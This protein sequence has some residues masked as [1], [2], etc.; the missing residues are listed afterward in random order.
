GSCSTCT[1][2]EWTQLVPGIAGLAARYG[3]RGH[4]Y[5]LI[6]SVGFYALIELCRVVI[7]SR[8]SVVVSEILVV[9]A[10][11]YYISHT[12][13]VRTQLVHDVW[14]ARPNLTTVMFRDGEM[15]NIL[16]S[17]FLICIR[18]AAERSTQAFSSQS[19]S[20]IDSQGDS[21]PQPWLSSVEF[22]ADIANPSVGDN[23]DADAFPGLEDDLDPRGQYDA[24]E[25]RG[26]EIELEEYT[27]SVERLVVLARG[28]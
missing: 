5:N 21:N 23:S 14:G 9:G 4:Q 24:S 26:D 19:L 27:V 2:R 10:T 20:F 1:C 22:A 7:I 13:S 6:D 28:A 17:R 18:E 12:S 3:S 15:S 16:I 11:W 8:T 25:G